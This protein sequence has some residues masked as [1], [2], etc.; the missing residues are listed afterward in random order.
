[1]RPEPPPDPHPGLVESAELVAH[2]G[3]E[4]EAGPLAEELRIK[5]DRRV[6][7][8]LEVDV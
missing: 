8:G 4:E 1:M 2:A 5:P 6:E 7:L 3:A